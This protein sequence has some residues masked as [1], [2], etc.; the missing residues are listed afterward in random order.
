MM[1]TTLVEDRQPLSFDGGHP[2]TVAAK[3]RVLFV[4]SAGG[5]LSQLLQL[6]PWWRHHDRRWVT[7]DLPDARSRLNGEHLVPAYYPTTRNVINMAKNYHLARR[8]LDEWQPDVVI[9]N[10]AGTAVP[11]FIEAKR[12]SIPTVYLEV[13]DRIDSKTLTGRMVRRFTTEFCVQW[14]E[15]QALYEN[16]TLV[17]PL[18]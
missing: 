12:R 17:G 5:H 18:Y 14:P 10:G 2:R 13:Y 3:R 6:E 7:F 15:Q 8:Q 11:F 16:S 1:V 9:S 4:S